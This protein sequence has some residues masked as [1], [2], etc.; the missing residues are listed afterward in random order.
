MTSVAISLDNKIIV[1]GSYDK[2]I[3]VWEKESGAQIKEL[4]DHNEIICSVFIS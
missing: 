4:K 2:T 1:S 3:R